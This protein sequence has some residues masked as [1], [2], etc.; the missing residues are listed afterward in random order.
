MKC[1]NCSETLVMTD[2][3]GVE[4]DYCPQCRGIWLDK[5]ELDKIIERTGNHYS[6]RENYDNDFKRY[7]YDEHDKKNYHPKK[8][9]SFLS[10]F[11][12]FD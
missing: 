12:D 5:G 11:L 2:R 7:G 3:N 10:D 1:P 6:S 9:K 8:K 4:I